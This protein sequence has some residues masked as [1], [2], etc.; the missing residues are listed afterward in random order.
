MIRRAPSYQIKTSSFDKIIYLFGRGF[1][2]ET[3]NGLYL[4]S[5]NF[6]GSQVYC[7]FYSS[8]SWLSSDFPPFS[9]YPV[10]NFVV[11]NNNVLYFTL[12]AFSSPQKL[13]I[14][15]AG[16]SG[17]MKASTSDPRFTYIQ[18][19]TGVNIGLYLME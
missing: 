13:D 10:N 2:Y 5:S 6:N 12:S 17:Y 3:N 16:P 15:Y 7:D 14:I 8:I 1:D 18:I 4:S 19:V 9:G 11:L